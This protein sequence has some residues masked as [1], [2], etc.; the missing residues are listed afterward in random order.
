ML[1][2]DPSKA[3][4]LGFLSLLAISIIQ[5]A[6]WVSE[7]VRYTH[8][9][10]RQL[11]SLYRADAEVVGAFLKGDVP[12]DVMGAMPHLDVDTATG[13]VRVHPAALEELNRASAR[14]GNRYI[15]E[16]A[17]FLAVL[18]GGMAVLT[19]AIRHDAE[20]RRR[21]QNF[22]AAVSHEFKS[23]IA[24]VRLA[25]ET[26]LLRTDSPDSKR[27]GQRILEDSERLL[28]MVDNLLD[29]TRLEEGRRT[30]APEPVLVR[31]AVEAGVAEVADRA[32]LRGIAVDVDVDEGLKLLVDPGALES[33]LRNLLDNAVKAC[34][35]GDGTRIAVRA[36][37]A[38]G[39]I[40]LS[41]SDDGLGF[42]PEEA[43]MIFEKF[44]RLGDEL[45]RSMAGTGLGL[46]IVK[47]LVEL[48]G[49]TV[50]AVSRGPGQGATVTI[51]WPESA[52]V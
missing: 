39:A 45:R 37:R 6:F 25:A 32:K 13:S 8:D 49:G 41:V 26:L 21:Q 9:V 30:L 12:D 22:L 7:N 47:R 31:D 10:Q 48:S 1:R 4:L 38:D 42:P 50:R 2:R 29:T 14:R 40:E 34:A 3:L 15:W 23:P 44:H 52:A 46:Y 19:R 27:L 20:L 36:K 16:G 5:V 35:A 24:S 43:A 11:A 28:R 51:R 17:F 33:I 18:V